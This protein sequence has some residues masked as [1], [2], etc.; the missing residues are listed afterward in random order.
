MAEIHL[1]DNSNCVIPVLASSVQFV[2][3]ESVLPIACRL[4][5]SSKHCSEFKFH[6]SEVDF[7]KKIIVNQAGV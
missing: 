3:T 1:H 6:Q 7:F 4:K 2:Q 5:S